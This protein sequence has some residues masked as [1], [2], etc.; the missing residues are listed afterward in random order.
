[1]SHLLDIVLGMAVGVVSSSLFVLAL[2]VGFCVLFG[3]VK[4]K[5]TRG[6]GAIVRSLDEVLTGQPVHYLSP[7]DPRGLADQL[8]TPELLE[9]AQRKS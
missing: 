2:F 8:H 3:L 5:P 1:V 6:R 7:S 9:A 4:L